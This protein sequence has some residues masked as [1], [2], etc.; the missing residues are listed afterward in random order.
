[1]CSV[2]DRLERIMRLRGS[3]WTQLGESC[4]VDRRTIF[5]WRGNRWRN[6]RL[7]AMLRIASELRVPL[8]WIVGETLDPSLDS[9]LSR[10]ETM[11]SILEA[12]AEESGIELE[13]LEGPSRRRAISRARKEACRRLYMT[14][15]YTLDE[16]GERLGGRDHSTVLYLVRQAE[17]ELV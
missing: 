16:I 17:A 8:G 12:V 6:A 4:G 10:S 2:T 9:K 1:M 14:G 13:E 7:D 5:A 15:R 11:D 3:S